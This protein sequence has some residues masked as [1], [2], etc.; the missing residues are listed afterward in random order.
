M[1]EFDVVRMIGRGEI[2]VTR[3]EDGSVLVGFDRAHPDHKVHVV[4]LTA[5]NA[6]RVS[7]AIMDVALHSAAIVRFRADGT[8]E[9]DI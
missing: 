1:D 6:M 3:T 4:T 8:E 9:R 7:A 2:L 5:R